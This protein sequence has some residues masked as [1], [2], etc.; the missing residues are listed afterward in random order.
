MSNFF[1]KFCRKSGSLPSS[2][3]QFSFSVPLRVRKE[4][5]W[6][7]SR[8]QSPTR[9]HLVEPRELIASFGDAF[10]LACSARAIF[11]IICQLIDEG[12]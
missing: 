8:P 2:H 3:Q 4:L 12:M 6:T 9:L 7:I 1:L 5:N 10:Y 11:F